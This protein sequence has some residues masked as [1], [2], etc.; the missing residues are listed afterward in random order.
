MQESIPSTSNEFNPED[1]YSQ[2]QVA[3]LLK[4]TVQTVISKR[5]NGLINSM[6]F[7]TRGRVFINKKEFHEIDM[8]RLRNQNGHNK[9]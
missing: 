5:K 7:C 2:Q 3:D 4:F 8:K 6:Q 9:L 1:Y